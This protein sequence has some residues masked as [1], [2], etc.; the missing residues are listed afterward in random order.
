DLFDA[1]APSLTRY[2]RG[3]GLPADI[4]DDIVQEAFV[5]LFRHLDLGRS[6]DNLRGWL[7]TVVHRQ[8]QKHRRRLARRRAVEWVVEPVVIEAQPSSHADPEVAYLARESQRRLQEAFVGL[9]E[10]Q[11]Q[12]LLLRAEG[13]TY[14]EMATVL[15][16]SLGSVAKTVARALA[17][18]SSV[19]GETSCA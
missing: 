13:L 2:V 8:A 11:Q 5:A 7:F 10:R 18:L 19:D 9:P 12:A 14:R 1:A 16:I 3:C 6:R 15:G 4:A 17:R